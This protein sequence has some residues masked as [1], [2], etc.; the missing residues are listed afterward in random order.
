MFGSIVIQSFSFID[1]LYKFKSVKSKTPFLNC[2]L[3]TNSFI[4]V[5]TS[6]VVWGRSSFIVETNEVDHGELHFVS[7]YTLTVLLY[8]AEIIASK[9][10]AQSLFPAQ[11]KVTISCLKNQLISWYKDP[12][13]AADE[14]LV[15]LWS[16]DRGEGDLF[17]ATVPRLCRGR[18]RPVRSWQ[19][20]TLLGRC[21]GS[22]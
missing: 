15:E 14:E 8:R 10:A 19:P 3:N 20:L 12:V 16:A 17:L 22:V 2:T 1:M 7:I 13:L 4:I 21:A 11:D 18:W 5:R 6:H 9:N